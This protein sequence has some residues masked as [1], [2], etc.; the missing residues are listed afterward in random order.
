MSHVVVSKN[1]AQTQPNPM[2]RFRPGLDNESVGWLGFCR[3]EFCG[4]RGTEKEMSV[5][6]GG[7]GGVGWRDTLRMGAMAIYVW[8]FSE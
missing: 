3:I 6:G 1:K 5:M 8:G 4:G 2:F 7:R